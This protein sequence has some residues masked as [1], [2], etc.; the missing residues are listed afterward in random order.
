MPQSGTDE[1]AHEAIE[2]EGL[3]L[4][5]LYLL[6]LVETLHNHIRQQQ[7]DAPQEGVPAHTEGTNGKSLNGGLPIDESDAP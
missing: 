3:K 6:L 4:L 2:E 1:H 5:V 7:A